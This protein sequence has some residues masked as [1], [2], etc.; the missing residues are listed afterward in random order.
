MEG[1]PIERTAEMVELI[2]EKMMEDEENGVKTKPEDQKGFFLI[3]NGHLLINFFK[4]FVIF[5][6]LS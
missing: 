5:L 2:Y 1:F 3:I 6:H 4:S